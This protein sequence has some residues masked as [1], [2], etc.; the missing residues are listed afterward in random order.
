VREPLPPLAAML[1][2]DSATSHFAGEG[3]VATV[4]ED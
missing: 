1:V 3:D 4:D 2:V